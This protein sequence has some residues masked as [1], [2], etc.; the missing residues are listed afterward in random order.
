MHPTDE[1]IPVLNKLRLS[2][3]LSTLELREAAWFGHDG[4]R[5]S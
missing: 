1:L 2:G 4:E 3:V 5:I